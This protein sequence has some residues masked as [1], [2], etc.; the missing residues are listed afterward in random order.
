VARNDG[1]GRHYFSTTYEQF[2]ADKA[3]AAANGE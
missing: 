2:L 1:T 3:K